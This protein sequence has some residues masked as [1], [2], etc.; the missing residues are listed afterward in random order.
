MKYA[1]PP[2]PERLRVYESHV[3]IS[4]PEGRV[5][6]YIYFKDNL[7]PRI[8]KLGK[9]VKVYLELLKTVMNKH[10]QTHIQTL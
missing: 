3:G 6:T 7:L 1:H 2:R 8:K 10:T 9:T 5:A 4:S